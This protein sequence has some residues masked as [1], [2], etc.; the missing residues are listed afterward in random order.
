[1]LLACLATLLLPRPPARAQP[2]PTEADAGR[3]WHLT[4]EL[5]TEVP[6]DL[7]LGAALEAPYGLRLGTS[8]GYVPGPYVDLINALSTSFE[9]YDDAT[10][11]LIRDVLQSSLVWTTRVGWRPWSQLT[12]DAA[13]SLVTLGGSATSEEVLQAFTT[14][15][16]PGSA[17]DEPYDVSSTLHMLRIDIGWTFWIGDVFLRPSIGAAVTLDA[18]TTVDPGST[19]M[20]ARDR[21]RR[22][23]GKGVAAYLDDTYTS[24]VHTPVLSLTAGYRFAL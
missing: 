2:A 5:G 1:V 13:Y 22:A 14:T 11:S 19:G 17:S 23:F 24:Y 6:V 18:G 21:A 10:A 12:I 8:L 4:A 20:P 3:P 16:P 15:P 7:A 9:F